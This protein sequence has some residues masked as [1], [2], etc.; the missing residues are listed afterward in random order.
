M[1]ITPEEQ[2]REQIFNLSPGELPKILD[3]LSQELIPSGKS[4]LNNILKLGIEIFKFD[5]KEDFS[6]EKFQKSYYKVLHK[7]VT[8]H[9]KFIDEGLINDKDQGNI[10]LIKFNKLFEIYHYWEQAIRSL[11]GVKVA[12]DPHYDSSMNTDIGL[13]RFNRIDPD[14]NSPYQNL[15]LFLLAKLSE[16]KLR[17]QGDRCMERVYTEDGYDTHAWEPNMT[18]KQ[19]V[20]RQTQKDINYQQWH[21]LTSGS[22]NTRNCTE[23]LAEVADPQFIDVVKDR[24]LFSFDNGIYES[25][26]VDENTGKYVD[27]FYFYEPEEGEHDALEVDNKRSACKYFNKEFIVHDYNDW[28]DIPTGHF[29]TIL[30]YQK[31]PEDVCRWMYILIG[32]LLYEVSEL[33]EWQIMPFLKGKAKSGKS[34]I[35]TKVCKEF[36]HSIDVGTLSNNIEKKFGLSSLKDCFMFIAPEIKNDIG[37]EQCDFQTIISGEDTSVAEKFKTAGSVRWTVPGIMAGNEPPG[38][39][40]NAGSIARR[41]CVFNFSKKV[42][43]ANTQLGKRLQEELP[44]ILVK[45]NRAYIEA[46]QKYGKKDIWD[47]TVLPKYF[48]KTQSDMAEQ[49]NALSHFLASGKLSYGPE[50]YMKLKRFIQCFNEHIRE[51]TLVKHAWNEDYFGSPFEDMEIKVQHKTKKIDPAT[52]RLYSANWVIG[53]N[54]EA[55]LEEQE[56]DDLDQ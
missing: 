36:F 20:Y 30:T 11:N 56:N 42:T 10:N 14:S 52:N 24:H 19:F 39:T 29:Q 6:I 40:D 54:I 27:R 46:V 16:G 38:Y 1:E 43:K 7:I 51:N 13:F 3:D 8:L 33:D 28:Y 2:Y 23:Y 32:R 53:C 21:N 5:E 41:L 35:I 55:D 26:V 47:R 31:F 15:I 4:G 25:C 44:S 9:H 37:L 12:S 45:A 48:R 17:R 22:S 49:T 50:K 18:I 34:T